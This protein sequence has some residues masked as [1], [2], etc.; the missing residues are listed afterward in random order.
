MPC[1]HCSF[2]YLKQQESP[3]AGNCKRRT[4]H[5]VACLSITFPGGGGGYPVL[6][7]GGGGYFIPS[8]SGWEG[9]PILSWMGG[10]RERTHSTGTGVSPEGHGTSGSIM[11]WRWGTVV[12]ANDNKELC[13]WCVD[14]LWPCQ[15]LTFTVPQV[16]PE[17][18]W[19]QWLEVLLDGDGVLPC[20]QRF[21]SVNITFPRTSY[22][23]CD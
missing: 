5:G 12:G 19:D 15:G 22:A 6:S 1:F 10:L 2:I 11:G 13:L 9:Y 4:A 20:G 21:P 23:G 16:P 18:T 7:L 3:P 8:C 14:I 17:R